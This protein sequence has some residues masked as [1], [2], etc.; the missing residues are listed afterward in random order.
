LACAA[1]YARDIPE[2]YIKRDCKAICSGKERRQGAAMDPINAT[3]IT[4]IAFPAVS[5]SDFSL[6]EFLSAVKPLALFVIGMAIY[7]IFIFK[8][9]QFLA[10]RDIVRLGLD[11]YSKGFTGFLR[12]MVSAIFYVVKNLVFVPAVVFFWFAVLA[13]LLLFLAKNH[14]ADTIL[15]TSISL[16]AAVRI[17]AY[18]NEDL[19]RDLAK[20]VPFALLG[21]FLV[22]V[23][24]FSV[25]HSLEIAKQAPLLWKQLL[26][27]LLFVIL[28]EFVLRILKGIAS[29]FGGEGGGR[30]GKESKESAGE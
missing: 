4:G 1:E 20:M 2:K 18:Y 17:T 19:S 28:L 30:K 11:R 21:V 8:F 22:D 12:K 29:L 23:S 9:Y 25:A 5:L 6:G 14:T 26:Y 3:N 13:L 15:M 7:A 10:R 24:Y 27:Y 16:V